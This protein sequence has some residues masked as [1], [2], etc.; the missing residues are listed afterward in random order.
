MDN[1]QWDKVEQRL[2][3]K[4]YPVEMKIDGYMVH[5]VLVPDKGLNQCILVYVDGKI[6]FKCLT[7]DCE[8]RRRFYNRH[9]KSLL[10]TADF[11]KLSIREQKRLKRERVKY[12]YEYF[13]P[14]WTSF[15]RLKAHLINNNN[16]IELISKL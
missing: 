11:K 16:S 10:R 12:E 15:A 6:D 5:L 3:L 1:V 7:E 14:D 4:G 2:K 13:T 8:I 9:I